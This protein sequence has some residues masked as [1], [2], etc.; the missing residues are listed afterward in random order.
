M[1]YPLCERCGLDGDGIQER[2]G[3]LG[4]DGPDADVQGRALQATVVAPNI[5][6]IVSRFYNVLRGVEAFSLIVDDPE[7]VSGLKDRHE[8][9][10]L[11]LGVH[12]RSHAY[13]EER[14]RIGAVHQRSGVP[15]SLYQCTYQGLQSLLIEKIPHDVR[16]DED[17][18]EAML[19]FVLKITSLD[20]SLAAESYC[21]ARVRDL[22]QSLASERNQSERLRELAV[23]DW[24]T[25]L[26]N[27]SY[28][29]RTLEALLQQRAAGDRPFCV[30]MA[31]LDHFK[32]I[33]D[34][35]GHLVG[36]EVLKICAA[37]MVAGARA[38]DEVCRY[39]GE[40][41]L[42]I[43]DGAG[44]V[45]AQEAAERV[46]SRIASN[47]IHC[48]DEE[49]SV[50][51][52]LGLAEVRASDTANSLIERADAALYAAKAAGRNCIRS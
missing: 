30:V 41:F 5:D 40:E 12:F 14:L 46:R 20:M 25:S 4:L 47:A 51:I 43:L 2:L 44:L 17:A 52:S 6:A 28:A 3:L 35:Y 27:H 22:K 50:S 23:T 49:I 7:T 32:A 29:R 13:F 8:K 18:Y 11:G 34:R 45:E 48:G 26:H 16:A 31:D 36:D 9:Y 19:G 1:D 42:L 24:L 33:N 38:G 37:R 39:G 15:Q 10:L 21:L